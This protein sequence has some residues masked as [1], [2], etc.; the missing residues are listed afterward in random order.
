MTAAALAASSVARAHQAVGDDATESTLQTAL[1]FSA[2]TAPSAIDTRGLLE[3]CENNRKGVQDKLDKA[4]NLRGNTDRRFKEFNVYRK[5]CS[6][7]DEEA[8]VRLK[9]E[10]AILRGAASHGAAGAAWRLAKA[11]QQYSDTAL[12]QPFFED[13]LPGFVAYHAYAS[14]D[15]ETG[16]EVESSFPPQQVP[17][18]PLDEMIFKARKG[19]QSADPTTLLPLLKTIHNKPTFDHEYLDSRLLRLISNRTNSDKSLK[20]F[21]FVWRLSGDSVRE[22][23]LWLL[24]AHSVAAKET[25]TL[26]KEI[27]KAEVRRKLQPAD[28]AALARGLIDGIANAPAAK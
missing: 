3:E 14:D 9:L 12:R 17:Y 18:D 20:T 8:Q 23:A 5:Q 10:R 26:W 22:D 24:A 25:P 6:I 15:P 28:Q 16:K 11:R 27:S 2:A 19:L 7:L 13:K 4:L 1:A 21:D